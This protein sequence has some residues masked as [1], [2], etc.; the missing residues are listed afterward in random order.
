MSITALTVARDAMNFAIVGVESRCL[1]GRQFRR[2]ADVQAAWFEAIELVET[3]HFFFIDDDDDLPAD[4]I[5]VLAQCLEANT[6]IAYTDEIVNGQ[7]RQRAPY[8]QEAH[9]KDPTLV[10][11]L[12]LC[13]TDVARAA[14]RDLPR[15]HFW[16]EMQ[17]YWEMAKRGGATHVPEIG[18]VWNRGDAGLHAE[19]FTVVGMSNSTAW[20][21]A[22]R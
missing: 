10:H 2:A 5:E 1:Y 18:Y 14:L 12:V 16:P 19:W 13:E 3:S 9:L 7:R 20:C 21:A 8:S 17:L 22:N 15:G 4:H 11:H 6:A